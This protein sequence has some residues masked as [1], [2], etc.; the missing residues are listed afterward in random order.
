MKNKILLAILL[1]ANHFASVYAQENPKKSGV[2]KTS[3]K[4]NQASSKISEQ[5]AMVAQ[6]ATQASLNIQ[7]AITNAKMALKVFEPILKLRLRK[8]VNSNSQEQTGLVAGTESQTYTSG[9]NDAWY[10]PPPIPEQ[11]LMQDSVAW[12]QATLYQQQSVQQ[13][14]LNNGVPVITQSATYNTD[15][16]ANLGNQNST[17]FGCYLNILNGAVMD[18][19]DAAGNSKSIDLIF[20]STDYF[21]ENVPMYAFLTPSFAKNDK[22]A[23]NFFKGTKY[24]DQ[25]IPPKLW[26]QV[27]ESEVAMTSLTGEQFERIQ[28]NQQLEAVVKQIAGFSQKIES[29][30]KLDNKVI[31]IKTE[32]GDRTAYG[33]LYIVSHTGTFG[34][35][36]YLKV[37]IK[38]TGLD[39][40]GDGNPDPGLYYNY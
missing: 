28:T 40:T 37:K 20:T 32:M 19:I 39:A 24:K 22:F 7:T 27:N 15:G 29:R 35:N 8:K 36:A 25:N 21:N 6:E 11:Q 23:Y 4:I 3:E 38:V 10:V 31:A 5:S 16:T 14:D 26:E 30:T 2:V 12:Q 34:E 17:K 33:L 18:E 9:S 1:F 13:T